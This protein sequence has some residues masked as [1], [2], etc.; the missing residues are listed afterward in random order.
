MKRTT[1]QIIDSI[2]ALRTELGM[3]VRSYPGT[4]RYACL[5][6]EGK[7]RRLLKDWNAGNNA[8]DNITSMHFTDIAR[9]YN[10]HEIDAL[11][12]YENVVMRGRA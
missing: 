6:V 8:T 2:N 1:R 12:F 5:I 4:S 10:L 7:F 9:A 11:A 3:D